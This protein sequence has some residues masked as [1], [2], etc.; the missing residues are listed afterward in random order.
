[1]PLALPESIIKVENGIRVKYYVYNNNILNMY[2]W[3]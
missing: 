2:Q 1:M 3:V